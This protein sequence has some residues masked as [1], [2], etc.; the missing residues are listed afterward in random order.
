M[1]TDKKIKLIP[2]KRRGAVLTHP[3]LPCLKPFHTLNLTAG[4][5]NECFYCYTQSYNFVP[6]WGTVIYFENTF[7]RLQAELPR[8]RKKL[9]LVYFSTYC[10]P[11]LPIE[12]LLE[13]QF[14]IMHL[15]LNSNISLL[16]S[17]K[18]VIP[19]KFIDMFSRFPGKVHIQ[20][21]IT[22]LND[23][24]RQLI[25]PYP[26]TIENRLANIER[27]RKNHISVESRI[28]P[29]VPGLTDTDESLSFL[30]DTLK[31][32]GVQQVVASYLF[33]RRGIQPPRQ[34]T[35]GSWS[36]KEMSKLYTYKVTDYCSGGT[37]W[38]PSGEYRRKRYEFLKK[39]AVS[40]SITVKQ[41][42]CKNKDLT[43]DCCHPLPT[44][45]I[46]ATIQNRFL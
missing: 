40:K 26:A 37:I 18:S 34:L 8:M 31:Q 41:C 29:L 16:I 39:I 23:K 11:F 17:T 27:L 4:C 42:S 9:R 3:L 2:I 13:T 45:K 24:I 10:E 20:I 21:G 35:F 46:P 19:E 1:I 30:L 5:P 32:L 28:D 36:V 33:L 12:P 43:D 22:T 14:K 15:L 25:E 44:L 7:E 38:L 6:R